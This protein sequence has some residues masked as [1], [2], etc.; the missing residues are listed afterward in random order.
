[1][2]PEQSFIASALFVGFFV[3]WLLWSLL[4]WPSLI[5]LLKSNDA[6]NWVQA[7]GAIAAIL[8][9][10]Y[11]ARSDT[12][13]REKEKIAEHEKEMRRIAFY[14]NRSELLPSIS[15]LLQINDF[16]PK[17]EKTIKRGEIK[18]KNIFFWV[19]TN[20]AVAKINSVVQE[21]DAT[22][23][24]ELR[25]SIFYKEFQRI[26]DGILILAP[27]FND[28][29]MRLNYEGGF[30]TPLYYF[31][32]QRNYSGDILKHLD[33]DIFYYMQEIELIIFDIRES[34][35]YIDGK[36]NRDLPE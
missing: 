34:F 6:A 13:A 5:D 25:T 8:V 30:G 12:R 17:A 16:L 9:S 33:G 24:M 36:I 22:T 15:R 18:Y 35:V 27:M 32:M 3:I 23:M 28:F 20:N 31:Q 7:F 1:M 26:F 29:K 11:I 4:K 19:M 10:A 14:I 2:T 21:I